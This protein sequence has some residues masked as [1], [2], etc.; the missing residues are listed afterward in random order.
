MSPRA[1]VNLKVNENTMTKPN[2]TSTEVA[3]STSLPD[4]FEAR[5]DALADDATFPRW[6]GVAMVIADAL[7]MMGA[8]SKMIVYQRVADKFSLGVSTVRL[9]TKYHAELGYLF[10]EMPY[11]PEWTQVRL[12]YREAKKRDTSAEA[13]LLGRYAEADKWGGQL[14]PARVWAAQLRDAPDDRNPV[15]A[16]LERLASCAITA[17]KA[18]SSGNGYSKFAS[19]L[20]KLSSEAD[21]ILAEAEAK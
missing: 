4:E 20:H 7:D 19:R 3:M 18:V 9:W 13:V 8:S 2:P 11:T 14:C 15:L 10:D 1:D 6:R 21:A 12:A 5:L 17:L 16:K